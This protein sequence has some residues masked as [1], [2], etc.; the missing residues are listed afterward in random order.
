MRVFRF[1]S[2]EVRTR[3]REL[4][5]AGMKVRLRGQP[6]QILEMLVSYP[7]KVVTR[8]EMQAK[9]WPAD[10]FV[11]FQHGLNVSIRKLRQALCESGHE[12]RYIETLP[13]V[14]YRFLASVES[15][16]E[17]PIPAAASGNGQGINADSNGPDKGADTEQVGTF[18]PLR[19]QS[20]NP[21][22]DL[23]KVSPTGLHD[24]ARRASTT[25]TPA[26]RAARSTASLIL[27][28]SLAAILVALFPLLTKPSWQ[29]SQQP[30]ANSP[31][32]RVSSVSAAESPAAT[33]HAGGL[34]T[35]PPAHSGSRA[36][37]GFGFIQG[38]L[39]VVSVAKASY[40]TFPPPAATPDATFIT[41]GIAYIGTPNDCYTIAAFLKKCGT[42]GFELKFSGIG[43][44]NLDGA[45]AGPATAMSGNTWGI[46]IEFTGEQ[47]LAHG[48][49]IYI[50]HDDGAALKIDGKLISG[51]DPGV[52]SPKLESA[53][54][55]GSTGMHSFDLLYA[56]A[57]G[58]G[59]WLS[60][61]P[62]L[63]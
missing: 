1:G 6:F 27:A 48:Q 56:N 9:L 51:F 8:E 18:G 57:S 14:G 7:G 43:N 11:D 41:G 55:T 61:F 42:K 50:L 28:S 16:E 4:Y 58:G 2:F 20:V 23:P 12:P 29:G 60:F 37:G 26:L 40:V 31:D 34:V 44:P 35:A 33:A 30:A 54:F 5:K 38:K 21:P 63:Y 62:A 10:T 13:G 47:N 32:S 19:S 25:A 3:T 59:A 53:A 17:D 49:E 22:V 46:M 36:S 15:S 52:T 45:A 39:W 24:E